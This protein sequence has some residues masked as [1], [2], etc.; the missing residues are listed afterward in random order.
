[1][2]VYF[3]FDP[4]RSSFVRYRGLSLSLPLSVYLFVSLSVPAH[5]PRTHTHIHTHSHARTHARTHTHT[6]TH[7]HARTHARA[8][9]RA[10][11]YTHSNHSFAGNPELSEVLLLKPGVGQAVAIQA[12]LSEFRSCVKVEVAVLGSPS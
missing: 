6:H 3:Q 5:P 8:R 9:A 7:T 11:T 10:H 2:Q 4:R 1:M 12:S